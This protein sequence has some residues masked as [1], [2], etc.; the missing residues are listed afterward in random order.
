MPTIPEPG[1]PCNPI[2][3]TCVDNKDKCTSCDDPWVNEDDTCK[4]TEN[5]TYIKVTLDGAASC[6]PCHL[7]CKKC[8]GAS[9]ND[10]TECDN[11]LREFTENT[12]KA[13]TGT[14]PRKDGFYDCDE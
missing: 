5:G 1:K 3:K 12:E 2:C 6:E 4:C 11:T 9:E 10:C 7:S 13:G 14:C 8:K